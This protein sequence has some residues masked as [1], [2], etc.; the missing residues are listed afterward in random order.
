MSERA[1]VVIEK[2]V[3]GGA[4][5]ARLDSGQAVFVPGV[6]PGERVIIDLK[7]KRKGFLEADLVDVISPSPHRIVPPCEGENQCTGATWPFIAYPAQ[8]TYK[9]EILLDSLKRIGGMEPKQLLPI[10][11]SSPSDHYRL[12]TQFT[13]R[14][15]QGKQKIGFFRQGSHELIEVENAFLLHPLIDKVLK[16]LRSM[17]DRLPLLKELHINVTPA[18][19]AHVLFFTE[20]E[21]YPPLEAL[22]N[23]LRNKAPEVIGISGF[24]RR[25]KTVVLGKNYLTLDVDGLTLR[26]TEG[27]FYQ[28]NWEQNRNMV[29]TVLDFSGLEGSETVL[30][31]YCGIGNFSLPLAKKTKTVIGIE[32]G[33]SAIEDAKK[34][35]ELNSIRNAEFIA[36]DTQKGLRTLLQRKAPAD[37]IV[38]DPPR[39]GATLKILER[40]LAFVPRKIIYVSCNPTTL[41][42]DLKFFSLFGLRLTRLQPVDMF[43]YT[44]HIECVTEMVRTE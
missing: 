25:K 7:K 10:K 34:N 16:A 3:Y 33:Y 6:L 12:R 14:S 26:A 35:S 29:R 13:V 4:G 15:V 39:A 38:L 37:I 11:P 23:D 17:S 31:L 18:G 44:Y 41:A 21:S 22:W 43:P 20:M 32:S 40:V 1:D 36:D 8:L 2:L 19:E 5:L 24:A 42:R 27:N 28:V 30:D 9:Q